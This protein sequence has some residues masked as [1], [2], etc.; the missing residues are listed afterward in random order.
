MGYGLWGEDAVG[1][2]ARQMG[3]VLHRVA[4]HLGEWAGMGGHLG[5]SSLCP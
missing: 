2:G 5:A 3:P 4:Q 1:C